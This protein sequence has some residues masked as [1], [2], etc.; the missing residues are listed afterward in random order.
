MGVL[1]SCIH[2]ATIVRSHQLKG[3]KLQTW[4]AVLRYCSKDRFRPHYETISTGE[5]DDG[6][7]I[8]S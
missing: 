6:H 2:H 1:L 4:H 8:G 7:G 3:S 5:I